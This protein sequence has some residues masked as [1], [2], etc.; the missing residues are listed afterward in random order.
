MFHVRAPTARAGRGRHVK[1]GRNDE[2][3][4]GERKRNHRGARAR[5]IE[6]LLL[7]FHSAEQGGETEHEQNISDDRSGDRCLHYTG[8]SFRERDAG[9]D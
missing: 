7:V 1:D 6:T 5:L 2:G 9:N 4:R 3:D 8:E